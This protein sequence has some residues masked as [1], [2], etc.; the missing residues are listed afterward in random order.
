MIDKHDLSGLSYEK[1][2]IV[3]RLSYVGEQSEEDLLKMAPPIRK[4]TMEYSNAITELINSGI[5]EARIVGVSGSSKERR[6]TLNEEYRA[7]V[8]EEMRARDHHL[9]NK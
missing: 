6:F 2:K 1:F 8:Y 9:K 7:A 4:V 3:K 5:I